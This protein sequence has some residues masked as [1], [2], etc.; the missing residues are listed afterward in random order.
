MLPV[1]NDIVDLRE[2]GNLGKSL[3][4]RFLARIFT[5][6]ERELIMR[7]A[8]PDGLLWALWASKEA[9]YKAISRDNPGVSSIPRRY[10]V[11]FDEEIISETQGAMTGP[12]CRRNGRVATPLGD[13]ALRID[14]TPE[15][16][17]ALAAGDKGDFPHIFER[18]DAISDGR[19]G[20]FDPSVVVR[21]RLLQEIARRL[22]C[23]ID[24]LSVLKDPTGP[25]APRVL[26]R[27]ELLTAGVSLSHDGRFAAFA[28][29]ISSLNR[30]P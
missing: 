28:L 2:P 1:G 25:G 15:Y 22:G 4:G 11:C 18:A 23:S 6:D 19:D 26:L 7:A 29:D 10:S 14:V 3:D 16:V 20:T 27:G 17:H 24:A 30:L 12:F 9:A 8:S 13:V 5:N 21:N